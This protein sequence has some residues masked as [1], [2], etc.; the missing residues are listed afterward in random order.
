MAE[1]GELRMLALRKRMKEDAENWRMTSLQI[2]LVSRTGWGKWDVTWSADKGGNKK[3][4]ARGR[5]W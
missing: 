2:C 4:I 3:R 1:S 5:W